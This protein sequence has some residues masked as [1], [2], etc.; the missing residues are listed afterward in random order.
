MTISSDLKATFSEV[1][2]IGKGGG[3]IKNSSG[4]ELQCRNPGDSAFIPFS[5]GAPTTDDHATTKAFVEA[6]GGGV[7]GIIFLAQTFK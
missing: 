1:L 2:Q 6:S 7:G 5:V 4:T 3:K